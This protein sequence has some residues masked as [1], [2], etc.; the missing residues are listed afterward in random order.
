LAGE[1]V[2]QDTLNRVNATRRTVGW[3]LRIATTDSSRIL[4]EGLRESA[5]SRRGH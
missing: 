4:V 1:P 2:A 3:Y 5:R